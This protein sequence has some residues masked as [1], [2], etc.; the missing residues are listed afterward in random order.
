M[1]KSKQKDSGNSV[2][3]DLCKLGVITEEQISAFLGSYYELPQADLEQHDIPEAVRKLLSP[4]FIQKY[5]VIPLK[6]VGKILRPRW[7]APRS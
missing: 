2:V 4:E 1:F 3:T 7:F 5:Q 6:R